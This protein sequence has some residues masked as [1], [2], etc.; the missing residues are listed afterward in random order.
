MGWIGP[1]KPHIDGGDL[2]I[3]NQPIDYFVIYHFRSTRISFDP[4]G[5]R[6]KSW[7]AYLT[8]P[9][10]GFTEMGWGVH[11]F[12]FTA[13]LENLCKS[14]QL[15]LVFQSENSCTALDMPDENGFVYAKERIEYLRSQS[16]AALNA[17]QAG[18]SLC[19]GFVWSLTDNFKWSEENTPC[20]DLVQVYYHTLSSI[21]KGEL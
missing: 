15:P 6:Q 21:L 13:V 9:L 16:A 1:M 8:K 17:I 3:I 20:F 5:G 7:T 11:P 19:C 2:E 4:Q 18:I 10:W 14:Y 12:G